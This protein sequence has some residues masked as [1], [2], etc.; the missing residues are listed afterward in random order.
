MDKKTEKQIE[1]CTKEF[2]RKLIETKKVNTDD[3]VEAL[4][5]FNKT[6]RIFSEY[7]Q[8]AHALGYAEGYTKGV[9]FSIEQNKN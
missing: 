4:F 1:T 6:L 3:P 2:A 7:L 9:D 8:K 5:E